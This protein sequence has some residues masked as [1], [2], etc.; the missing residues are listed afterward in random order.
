M[1]SVYCTK[2]KQKE[3]LSTQIPMTLCIYPCLSATKYCDV[4]ISHYLNQ[5]CQLQP[6]T[7]LVSLDCFCPWHQYECI[8]LSVFVSICLYVS[9]CLRCLSIYLRLLLITTQVN[10]SCINQLNKCCIFIF[11][12]YGHA[13]YI[14]AGSD[15]LIKCVVSTCQ[16]RQRW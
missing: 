4:F 14:M 13:V 12:L 8:C 7:H 6:S 2:Q 15:F 1:K 11:S 10:W 9:A 16:K 5:L 3:G